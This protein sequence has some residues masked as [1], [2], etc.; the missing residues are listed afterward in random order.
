MAKTNGRP[1]PKQAEVVEEPREVALMR[2]E[3]GLVLP[4][5]KNLATWW[6]T[7]G[8][9][10]DAAEATLQRAR[11]LPA[12]TT[13]G[14][15]L[16]LQESLLTDRGN[17][18]D[19]EAHYEPVTGALFKMH[20]RLTQSRAAVTKP[21]E[22][23]IAI[24]QR[25]HNAYV[26]AER[27]RVEQENERLRRQAEEEAR[28]A[29]QRELEELERQAVAAEEASKFLSTRESLFVEIMANTGNAVAAA[30]AAGFA[31]PL[32]HGA[33]LMTLAKITTAI[34]GLKDAR[35]IRTQA[36]AVAAQPALPRQ[37]V[38]TERPAVS[39]ASGSRSRETWRAVFDNREE[40]HQAALRGEVPGDVLM[41]DES[42]VQQYARD[43]HELIDAWPGVHADKDTTTY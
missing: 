27:R 31:D 29:Q 14:D 30:K 20:R 15:D 16:A 19:A 13:E 11:T 12:V 34:N 41:I 28:A 2:Q 32:K 3:H 22:E 39:K 43:L 18:K 5:M 33:R 4:L 8:T 1:A 7:A 10:R 42:R 24:K 9:L 21:L 17:L 6:R 36:V 25:L 37:M 23:S 26:E 38:Q 40:L 35:A